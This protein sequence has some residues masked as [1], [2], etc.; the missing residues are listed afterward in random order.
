M[1]NLT[2]KF[3]HVRPD[4]VSEGSSLYGTTIPLKKLAI[5]PRIRDCVLERVWEIVPFKGL[6]IC[7]YQDNDIYE[8]TKK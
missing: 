1:K 7:P 3:R 8:Q 4:M 2:C 5:T 6:S